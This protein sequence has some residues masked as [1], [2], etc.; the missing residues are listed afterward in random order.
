MPKARMAKWG[1]LL[2]SAGC[3]SIGLAAAPVA[4][5]M[6]DLRGLR[7]GMAETELPAEGFGKFHCATSSDTDLAGWSDWEK[8]PKDNDG[9]RAIRFSYSTG[10]TKVAGH[11]VGLEAW[12]GADGRLDT[13]QIVTDSKVP[14]FLRKKAFLLGLQAR[15]RYGE[16]GWSCTDGKPGIDGDPV[17]GVFVE[18]TCHKDLPDRSLQVE[19][20]LLRRPG[21]DIAAFVGETR[22]TITATR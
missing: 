7:V 5:D 18:E 13:L 3:A 14:M 8:C 1:R 21:T 17:G 16:E 10:E 22:I 19:R 11:P 4:G 12:F 15:S 20:V 9:R 2:V 6:G